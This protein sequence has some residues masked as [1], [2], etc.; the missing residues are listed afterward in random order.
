MSQTRCQISVSLDGF[1]AGP[2]QSSEEPLGKGGERLHQWALVTEGWR[3]S[4]GHEGGEQSVD[5]K[6]AAEGMHNVGAVVMGRKMF[7]GAGPWDPEWRGW[8]GE[9][10]PFH[11][12]V[13]VVTHNQR[14][15]LE[16]EGGTTFHFVNDGIEAAHAAAREAAGERDVLVAGGANTVQQCL[17]AGLLD[18]VYLHIAPVILGAGE[19]LLDNVGDLELEPVEVIHSPA[20]THIRYKVGR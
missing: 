16:M 3:A 2:D 14:E 18:E 1:A 13:F 7:A 5:S 6:V 8:W 15:P 17:S 10:P 12:P 4:H 9:D 11:A 19:R 20:A